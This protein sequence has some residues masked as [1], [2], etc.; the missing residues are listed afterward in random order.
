MVVVGSVSATG[1]D[2][3]KVSISPSSSSRSII[4]LFAALRV[5]SVLATVFFLDFLT[6][7]FATFFAVFRD[8]FGED[9]FG[10]DRFAA[11]VAFFFPVV[12]L[13]SFFL[14]FLAMFDSFDPVCGQSRARR[15]RT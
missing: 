8:L 15:T 14:R 11:L 7:F 2:A 4:A 3:G 1:S 10:D 13:F 9:L 6:V 12:L 5:D